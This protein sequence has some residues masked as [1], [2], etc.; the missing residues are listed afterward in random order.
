MTSKAIHQTLIELTAKDNATPVIKKSLQQMERYYAKTTVFHKGLSSS[1]SKVSAHA[2]QSFS[3]INNANFR[4]AKSTSNS[5]KRLNSFSKKSNKSSRALGKLTQ[6]V[7]EANT[8]FGMLSGAALASGVA[9]GV[10]F[11]H[12][13]AKT[14]MQIDSFKNAMLATTGSFELADIEYEKAIK[15]SKQLGASLEVVTSTYGKYAIAASQAG[16]SNADIEKTYNSLI[17]ASVAFGLSQEKTKLALKA[18]EQMFSKGQVQ[19]EE[20]RGQLGEQ[21]PGAFQLAAKAMNVTTAELGAM[22]KRGEVTA[23]ELLP[24][25]AIELDRFTHSAKNAAS[26]QLRASLNRLN[27]S[28]V[29]LN[30]VILKSTNAYGGMQYL[31]EALTRRLDSLAESISNNETLLKGLENRFKEFSSIKQRVSE[32]TEEF[33]WLEATISLIAGYTAFKVFG[34]AISG[35]KKLIEYF[36]QIK[37]LAGKIKGFIGDAKGFV[38]KT[39]KSMV[40][41]FNELTNKSSGAS[42]SLHKLNLNLKNHD[43]LRSASD[44]AKSFADNLAKIAPLMGGVAIGYQSFS[45]LTSGTTE[46]PKKNED[47]KS[48]FDK[49]EKATELYNRDVENER[50]IQQESLEGWRKYFKSMEDYEVKAYAKRNEMRCKSFEEEKALQERL[51]E[52]RKNETTFTLEHGRDALEGLSFILKTQADLQNKSTKKGF[53][54]W[55]KLAIAEATI[56]GIVSAMNAYKSLSGIPYIGVPLAIAAAASVAMK[57]AQQIGQIQAQTFTPSARGGYDI[58]KGVNP[59]TQL[60]ER[61]MVLPAE[62]AE[63]IRK[64]ASDR[65]KDNNKKESVSH[66]NFNISS[67][68]GQDFMEQLIQNR[69][70]I[71]ALVMG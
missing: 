8:A 31:V 69:S 6:S 28:W 20:L 34:W 29:E 32:V 59:L 3:G 40:N 51:E 17:S 36:K 5:S 2:K 46:T 4:L 68:G 52:I 23:S 42:K 56:T 48:P 22:L 27:T 58:P 60:H 54:N 70:L 13:L 67:V 1:Y 47:D 61:E 21:L 57:T 50:K 11:T 26:T 14:A 37:A 64:L 63:V 39:T 38:D 35:L 10:T 62:H 41:K 24:K 30:D 33:R 9:V 12:S 53:E 65:N 25:L 18:V 43:G 71:K 45:S 15:R 7:R 66:F 44:Y 49:H 16:V 55:K 19:A